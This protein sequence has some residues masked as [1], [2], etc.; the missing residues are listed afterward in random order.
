MLFA[1]LCAKSTNVDVDGSRSA[2][3]LIAPHSR[4]QG[5]SREHLA[6]ILGEELEQFIFHVR[7]VEW[8]AAERGLVGLEVQHETR[9]FHEGVMPCHM[10][11]EEEVSQASFE[12]ARMEWCETEVVEQVITQ[13][14]IGELCTRH[15]DEDATDGDLSFAQA[16][17]NRPATLGV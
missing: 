11:R 4:E 5:L 10:V 14:K 3:V 2:E 16:S 12:F 7:E 17:A 6:G 1:E 15:E 8:V 13:F 9:I